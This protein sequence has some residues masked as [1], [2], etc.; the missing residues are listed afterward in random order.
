MKPTAALPFVIL[1]LG[2]T[3]KSVALMVIQGQRRTKTRTFRWPEDAAHWRGVVSSDEDAQTLRAQAALRNDGE[4]QPYFLA[5]VAAWIGLGAEETLAL[6]VCG[7]Y[8][9]LRG[10]HSAFLIWPRQPLRN[11]LFGL[12]LLCLFVVLADCVRLLLSARG[13]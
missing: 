4:S 9:V 13:R 3:L 1:V 11:R 8:L 2:M 10:L 6:I 12:S 7:T 5:A